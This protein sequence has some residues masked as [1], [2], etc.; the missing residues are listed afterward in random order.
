VTF[1][2]FNSGDIIHTT[3]KT[4][5]SFFIEN[6]GQQVT[7]SVFLEHPY[8]E[9]NLRYRT[10][11]GFSQK[12][13]GVIVKTGS[14]SASV[15]LQTGVSGGTNSVLWHAVNQLYRYYS[16]ENSNY[17][18]TFTGS[19]ATT[20][21]VVSVPEIYYDQKILTGSFTGSDVNAA[22]ASRLIYDDGR[23]GLYSGSVSGTLI[24]SIFYSE[25]I[26]VI[27]K[28]DL[29]NFGDVSSTNLNWRFWLKGVSEI[30]VQIFKCRAPAGEL[31]ASTNP[32][33]Y[34]VPASGS[35][36]NLREIVSSSL[37]PYITKVGLL[38]DQ[39]NVVAI[40]QLAQPIKKNESD[41]YLYKIKMDW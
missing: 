14:M 13:G 33:F 31:N 18:L 37:S 15:D 36:K 34:T 8:L 4:F 1:Y 3:I 21:R 16:L 9:T 29:T 26:A 5:P 30:P 32:T 10:F 35:H 24:G 12:Q 23:G 20:I 25:G 2:K 28:G 38:D 19:K 17:S 7:G 22:G 40:A 39:F 27:T 11:Q 6:S 41:S